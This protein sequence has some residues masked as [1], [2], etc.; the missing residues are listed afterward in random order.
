MPGTDKDLF[1]SYAHADAD[2]V[3]KLASDLEREGLTVFLDQW[4]IDTAEY[5]VGRLEAGIDGARNAAM[6]LSP[7]SIASRWVKQE[8][9][10]LISRSVEKDMPFIPVL[11]RDATP[12]T[13]L[14]T[15]QWTDFRDPADYDA[16][17]ADL[18][19]VL[20]GLPRPRT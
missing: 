4:D 9:N 20:R 15:R 11:Y 8:Y 5:F 7:D 3:K 10:A 13:F 18:V 14:G 19:R 16:R 17:L 12:P 6:I 2:W 1:I